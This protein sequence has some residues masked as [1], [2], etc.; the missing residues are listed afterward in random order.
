METKTE[1]KALVVVAEGSEEMETVVVVDMLRRANIT[2]TLAALTVNPNHDYVTFSRNVKIVPDR[3]LEEIMD[4]TDFDVFILPGGINGAKAFKTSKLIQN[5]LET[6]LKDET[7]LVALLCAA[8]IAL[9]PLTLQILA[10][11]K[12]TS[13]PSVKNQFDLNYYDYSEDRVVH[14]GNLITS[15][16]PGTSCEFSLKII[17][18]LIGKHAAEA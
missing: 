14:D 3:Y 6:Y 9:T 10:G 15:R 12:I 4:Q 11:K 17:E 18:T 13:H 8:P 16:G 2:V 1:T 7:K 5:L